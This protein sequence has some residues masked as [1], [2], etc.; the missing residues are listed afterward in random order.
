MIGPFACVDRIS[1]PLPRRMRLL[2]GAFLGYLAV[3]VFAVQAPEDG[4]PALLRTGVAPRRPALGCLRCSG[5][6]AAGGRASTAAGGSGAKV[7]AAWVSVATVALIAVHV[8]GCRVGIC[9]GGFL[10]HAGLRARHLLGP[11]FPHSAQAGLAGRRLHCRTGA[12]RRLHERVGLGAL[13]T[14]CTPACPTPRA[15]RTPSA[16]MPPTIFTAGDGR[17]PAR[18]LPPAVP[19][20]PATRPPGLLR[21]RG[22]QRG[23]LVPG[24]ADPRATKPCRSWPA[25]SR[26]TTSRSSS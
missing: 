21:G 15:S 18:L 20:R 5:R 19:G 17:R 13:I 6:H 23:V 16:A 4:F 3:A 11:L 26:R 1:G 10:S 12:A 25:S 14:T 9:R 24:P 8:C 7:A 2:A 22:I